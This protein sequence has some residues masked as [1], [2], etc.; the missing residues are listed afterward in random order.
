MTN[1][2]NQIVTQIQTLKFWQNIRN[3]KTKI[4]NKTK[5]KNLTWDETPKPKLLQNL[6]KTQS[7]T[8][9]KLSNCD[10]TQTGTKW[11]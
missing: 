4:V 8:K 3:S 9:L 6:K 1:K 7:G 11:W 2:K 10:N 5:K